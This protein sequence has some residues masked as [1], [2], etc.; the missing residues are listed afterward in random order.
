[1]GSKYY[2]KHYLPTYSALTCEHSVLVIQLNIRKYSNKTFE[3]LGIF[4]LYDDAVKR[5]NCFV[6]DKIK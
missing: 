2:K 3:R 5:G 1:M 6:T 4:I